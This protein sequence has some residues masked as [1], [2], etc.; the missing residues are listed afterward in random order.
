MT[1]DGYEVTF[2]GDESVL[3]LKMMAKQHDMLKI[4]ELYT[5]KQ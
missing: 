4:T 5:P 2:R 1:T 3:G